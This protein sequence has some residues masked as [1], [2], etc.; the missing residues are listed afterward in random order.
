[1]FEA[2][3]RR[4]LREEIDDALRSF[5][6]G[7]ST[8]PPPLVDKKEAARLMSVD[9]R[10]IERLIERGELPTADTSLNKVLIP[11]VAIVGFPIASRA[12]LRSAS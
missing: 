2:E 10:S 12:R 7:Q 4:M 11:Y 6:P 3:L 1:M 9:V 5:Q 8:P